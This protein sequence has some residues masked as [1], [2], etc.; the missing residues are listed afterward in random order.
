MSDEAEKTLPADP[1][2][3]N[4]K[5]AGWAQACLD[6]MRRQ[7]RC[8]EDEALS[9]LLANLMHW[10]DR[11][12]QDFEAC[13]D[14]A[15]SNYAAETDQDEP[16]PRCHEFSATIVYECEGSVTSTARQTVLAPDEKK[17]LSLFHVHA[18][19]GRCRMSDSTYWLLLDGAAGALP[20]RDL[21]KLWDHLGT[22]A[23]N[24]DGSLQYDFL[25]FPHGTDR[26]DVWHWFEAENPQFS[27]A[28]AMGQVPDGEEDGA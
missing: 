6:E 3:M 20:E 2:G 27:V 8:E 21:K 10:A 22:V 1:E 15:R 14:R 9:D 26:E 18:L 11:N 5:R 13:L 7:T 12:D 16:A 23:V 4:D 24:D 17:A 25:H 19:A 28:K